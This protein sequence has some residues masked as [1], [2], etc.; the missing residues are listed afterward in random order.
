MFTRISSTSARTRRAQLAEP[1][2]LGGQAVRMQYLLICWFLK[3]V[4]YYLTV[5]SGF[6]RGTDPGRTRVNPEQT[7]VN[8]GTKPRVELEKLQTNVVATVDTGRSVQSD[9]VPGQEMRPTGTRSKGARMNRDLMMRSVMIRALVQ[10]TTEA[11]NTGRHYSTRQ[12]IRPCGL[13]VCLN[14]NQFVLPHGHTPVDKGMI[15]GDLAIQR[16]AWIRPANCMLANGNGAVMDRSAMP[17][18]EKKSLPTDRTFEF[19]RSAH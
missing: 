16:A 2:N 12:F 7:Q 9:S 3:Q 11:Q 15:K 6:G 14:G 17:E 4:L 19:E 8:P 18:N 10:W 5:T 1:S 13:R